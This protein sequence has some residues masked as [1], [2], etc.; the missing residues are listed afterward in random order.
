MI[1]YA[2]V[3]IIYEWNCLNFNKSYGF[4]YVT[5]STSAESRQS[6]AVSLIDEHRRQCH[7]HL[8]AIRKAMN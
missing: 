2:Y 8:C 5:L 3:K 4:V 1:I 7:H 6:H